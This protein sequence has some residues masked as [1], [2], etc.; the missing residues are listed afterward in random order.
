MMDS[1]DS[2]FE[3]RR[4]EEHFSKEAL[5]SQDSSQTGMWKWWRRKELRAI[6]EVLKLTPGEMVLDAG[7]GPG[8]YSEWLREQGVDVVA[9]DLSLP[10]AR[11]V[12]R[13][14]ALPT[15]VCNLEQLGLRWSFE[16]VL[17][18]GTIEF[19]P[20]PVRAI[21]QLGELLNEEDSR[22]VL[23]LPADGPPGKLYQKHNERQGLRV[24][25]FTPRMIRGLAEQAGL[26]LDAAQMVGYNYVVR[27]TRRDA[28]LSSGSGSA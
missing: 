17:C 20:H 24:H 15:V 5:R 7:C 26:V 11:S 22:M 10:M 13:R 16:A 1:D 28:S 14:L 25:L 27:M 23:M 19:C 18:V 2:V 4:V 8:H 21:A 6:S 12:R 3:L 9:V